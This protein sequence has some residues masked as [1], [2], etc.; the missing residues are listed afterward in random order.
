MG[1]KVKR[2][3]FS[4]TLCQAKKITP[5]PGELEGDCCICGK[6]T[7]KGNKKKFGANFTCGDMVSGGDVICEYCQV[8]VKNSNT[9]RRTMFLVTPTMFKK[10]K[11]DEAK[12]IILNLP[13]EPFYLYLTKTWQKIGWIKLGNYLNDLNKSDKLTIL[14][15]YDVIH[16]SLDE[17]KKYW[18]IIEPLR[19]QKIP[20]IV[21]E[22]GIRE[23]YEYK[24]LISVFGKTKTEEYS[25]ILKEMKNNPNWLLAVYLNE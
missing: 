14:V 15:D 1:S 18:S 22:T 23:L 21:F 10:F 25:R 19:E 8:L 9:Y 12:N 6:H 3:Y 20:K 11:K 5:L 17:L 2:N 4:E 16:T 7:I 13:K 24:K